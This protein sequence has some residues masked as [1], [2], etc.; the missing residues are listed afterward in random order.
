MKIVLGDISEAEL[1]SL[2]RNMLNTRIFVHEGM[3]IYPCIGCMDCF[4]RRFGHCAIRDALTEDLETL[5]YF[6]EIELVS[7]CTYGGLSPLVKAALD[8]LFAYLRPVEEVRKKETRFSMQAVTRFVL[9]LRLYGPKNASEQE[10]AQEYGRLL[11]KTLNADDVTVR[12]YATREDLLAGREITGVIKEE[13]TDSLKGS[14]SDEESL[15]VFD[16]PDEILRFAQD[17]NGSDTDG[18]LRFAQDVNG[19]GTDEILRF[20]QDDNGSGTEG[21]SLMTVESVREEEA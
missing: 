11:A 2:P 4:A 15:Q 8:R 18:I 5:G 19:S 14:Q 10:T 6:E 12:I 20:A 9:A 3:R 7:A 16:N 21:E 13:C 17:D 1:R